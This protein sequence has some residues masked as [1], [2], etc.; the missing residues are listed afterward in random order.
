[1]A[2]C[3]QKKPLMYKIGDKIFLSTRNIKTEQLSKKLDN[4]NIGPFKIKKLERLLY[5]LELP[6]TIK[7]HDVFHPNLLQ[8]AANNPLPSQ[9]NIPPLATVVNNKEEWEVDNILDA[10]CDK[11]GKK[12]LFRVKWKGYNNDKVWYNATNFDHV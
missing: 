1:M 4:K 7:I 10:K 3:H 11:S 6:H 12:V 8:K 2:N 9:Q 5:Q